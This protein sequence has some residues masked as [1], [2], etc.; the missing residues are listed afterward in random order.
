MLWLS[1]ATKL[2]SF[3]IFWRFNSFN[4]NPRQKCWTRCLAIKKKKRHQVLSSNLSMISKSKP[5]YQKSVIYHWLIQ[6][7]HW[8]LSANLPNRSHL[9]YH[10]PL[11]YARCGG[12]RWLA[13]LMI[14]CPKWQ[15]SYL[16]IYLLNPYTVWNFSSHV[17]RYACDRLSPKSLLKRGHPTLFHTISLLSTLC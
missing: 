12:S 8:D 11:V 17:L 13:S 9:I 14:L 1:Y 4:Y 5:K 16:F 10:N 7:S 2:I 15:C 3:K 6:I